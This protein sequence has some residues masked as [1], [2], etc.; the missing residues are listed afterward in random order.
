MAIGY[1]KV[2]ILGEHAVVYGH[3]A[4][5]GALDRGV[6]LFARSGHYGISIPDWDLDV[7]ATDAHPVARALMR[8]ASG[9]RTRPRVRLEGS[10]RIPAAAGLGSS[11]AMSVAAVRALA[12]AVTPVRE[13]NDDEVAALANYGEHEF[14]QR[15]SGVDV[16]LAARGGLGT[17][18]LGV[19]FAPLPGLRLTLAIGL[20]GEARST[21]T[22]VARVASAT[23]SRPDA[24]RLARLGQVAERGAA[25]LIGGDLAG[26]GAELDAAQRVLTD[27]GLSSPGIDRL[28]TIARDHGALGAKLTGAGGGGAV[29]AVAPRREEQI[30][31]A[32][33][34][35]GHDGFVATIG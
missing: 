17:F 7:A 23:G 32:W 21:A 26:L 3:Q 27:L 15:P 30:V 35:A 19:G 25:A 29:I 13:L 20:T 34:S 2:I 33:R 11:A 9:L 6:E 22:M 10:A 12:A 16:Q 14:H 5:A 31:R 1:G 18:R 28:T 24:P 8:L 4:L